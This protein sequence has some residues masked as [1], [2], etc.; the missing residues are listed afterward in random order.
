MPELPQPVFQWPS[1]HVLLL[2]VSRLG[3]VMTRLSQ[4]RGD[5]LEHVFV[6]VGYEY[7]QH[8]LDSPFVPRLQRLANGAPFA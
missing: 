5:A 1:I 6:V 7:V 3:D 4:R 8:G 2:S